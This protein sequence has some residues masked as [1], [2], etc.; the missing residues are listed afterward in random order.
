MIRSPQ[1]GA[2]LM[3]SAELIALQGQ[4]VF[5]ELDIRFPANCI[6][7]MLA[8]YTQGPLSSSELSKHIGLSRQLIESR[9]KNTVQNNYFQSQP[10]EHDSRK[11]V[12]IIAPNAMAEAQQIVAIM[13]DFEKVYDTLWNEVGVDLEQ[14]LKAMEKGLAK[15]SLLHRLYDQSPHLE[16]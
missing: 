11:R 16:P 8:L 3:R 5:D 2:I 14:A 13:Q 10:D 6:S 12:Y 1:F 7:I 15:R 9:L 4:E